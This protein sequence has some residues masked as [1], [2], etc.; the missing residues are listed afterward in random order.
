METFKDK[1]ASFHPTFYLMDIYEE[2]N[3]PKQY[4]IIITSNMF[5]YVRRKPYKIELGRDHLKGLL[6]DNGKIIASHM[7]HGKGDPY[8]EKEV[9]IYSN[10][11]IYEEFPWYENPMFHYEHPVGYSYTKKMSTK[12]S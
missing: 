2:N 7:V 11:F 5:E 3:I 10:D 1:L 8:F 9:E 6:K 12:N 4:D